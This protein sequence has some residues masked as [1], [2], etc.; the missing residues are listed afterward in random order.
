M[1]ATEQHLPVVLFIKLHKVILLSKTEFEIISCDYSNKS[2]WA[3]LSSR[4]VYYV[5]QVDSTFKNWV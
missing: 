2:Y 4:A 3:E 1:K 5:A